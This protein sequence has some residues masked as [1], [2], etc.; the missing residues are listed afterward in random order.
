MDEINSQEI[1]KQSS[2]PSGETGIKVGKMMNTSNDPMY[3]F[4][5]RYF[6]LKD[7]DR[8]LEIGFGNGN[9][10]SKYF[11]NNPNIKAYGIDYSETMCNEA[12]YSNK[13]Y[14]DNNQLIL[15]CEDSLSTSFC[16]DY[17]DKIFCF[18]IIYF[19]DPIEIQI[20]EIK[21]ILKEYGKLF[22]GFRPRSV[23]EKLA[24][25]KNFSHLFE[26]NEIIELLEN[27]NFRIIS[28]KKQELSRKSLDGSKIDSIDIVIIGE[29]HK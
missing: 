28:E 20:K 10:F 16:N 27:N 15:K 8:I 22:L 21:R 9:F 25:T 26:S 5:A 18:N 7:N 3:S 29:N 14:I 11:E 4:A 12:V 6:D 24:F 1:G 13:E 17:F 19:W 23:M 2:K